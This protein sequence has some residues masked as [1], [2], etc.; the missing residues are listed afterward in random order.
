MAIPDNCDN[1]PRQRQGGA[2]AFSPFQ[3]D[4]SYFGN[5]AKQ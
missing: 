2:T 5:P 4:T 1:P 3:G